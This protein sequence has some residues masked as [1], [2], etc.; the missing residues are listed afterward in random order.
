[1]V[2]LPIAAP[3]VCQQPAAR[4]CIFQKTTSGHVSQSERVVRGKIVCP[5]KAK[6]GEFCGH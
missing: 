3:H 6:L 4:K 2:P 5:S 1:M